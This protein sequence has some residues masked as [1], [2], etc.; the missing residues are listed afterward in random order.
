MLL[1]DTTLN[2][3]W[4]RCYLMVWK[5]FML[6]YILTVFQ[7]L[8]VDLVLIIRLMAIVDHVVGRVGC[9]FGQLHHHSGSGRR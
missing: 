7:L 1:L 8:L 4:L 9:V 2:A 5:V 6:R 3:A